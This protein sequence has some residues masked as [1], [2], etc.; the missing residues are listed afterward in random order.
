MEGVSAPES[1]D[2]APSFKPE[3]YSQGP[4]MILH[5][6]DSDNAQPRTNP[7]E[8]GKRAPEAVRAGKT[9]RRWVTLQRQPISWPKNA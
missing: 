4:E 7:I 1:G 8:T 6:H 5:Q 2:G 9:G 3:A